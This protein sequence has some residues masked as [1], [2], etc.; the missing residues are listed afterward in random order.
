MLFQNEKIYFIDFLDS[1]IDS[2]ICDIIKLRQDLYY[3][4][5]LKTQ[6]SKNLRHKI[7][8]KKFWESIASRNIEYLQSPEFKILDIINYLRIEPYIKSIV[9]MNLIECI[10][11][12][13]SEEIK[14]IT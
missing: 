4:W 7:I 9:H 3:L 12:Q 5:N 1:Y 6:S 2:Y 8:Y 11:N 13:K 14:C 10:I